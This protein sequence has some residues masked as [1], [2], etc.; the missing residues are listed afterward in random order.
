MLL[1]LAR[2]RHANIGWQHRGNS[3]G[4]TN[5]TRL[6]KERLGSGCLAL[7]PVPSILTG[8]A[9]AGLALPYASTGRSL[10]NKAS[11][12]ARIMQATGLSE[13]MMKERGD[14]LSQHAA[15]ATMVSK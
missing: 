1:N 13:A 4:R 3:Y 15:L 6:A 5:G 12:V 2:V 7:I 10:Q 9:G 8:T 11:E 14:T